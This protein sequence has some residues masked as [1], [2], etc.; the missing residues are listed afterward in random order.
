LRTASLHE[1]DDDPGSFDLICGINVASFWTQP[2]RDL[3]SSH[4]LLA[5]G[6]ALCLFAQLPSWASG[7]ASWP[8]DVSTT[9]TDH[10]FVVAARHHG[11]VD[12]YP[13]ACVIARTAHTRI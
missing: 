4:R 11:D 7:G 1:L 9:L 6:G 3:K 8:D 10:G 2:A 13:I 5:P 12:P